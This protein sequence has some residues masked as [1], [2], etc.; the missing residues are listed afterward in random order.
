MHVVNAY[1]SQVGLDKMT[2]T[3]F[4]SIKLVIY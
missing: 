2:K 4:K 1:A 3:F